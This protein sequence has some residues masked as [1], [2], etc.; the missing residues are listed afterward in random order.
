MPTSE[1]I[2]AEL[3]RRVQRDELYKTMKSSAAAH[4][5]PVNASPRGY[6]VFDNG[7]MLSTA[8]VIDTIVLSIFARHF[9]E[10]EPRDGEER[11]DRV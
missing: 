3:N 7:R 4:P 6:D 2:I 11:R 5:D 8:S 9:H 1:E 10:L